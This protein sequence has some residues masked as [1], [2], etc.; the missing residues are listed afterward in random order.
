VTVVGLVGF[1]APFLD[2]QHCTIY[3]GWDT[4]ASLLCG[5]ALSTTSMAVVYAVMLKPGSTKPTTERNPWGLLH[6]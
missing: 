4:Q 6:Q 2:A 3:F 1:I 5:V